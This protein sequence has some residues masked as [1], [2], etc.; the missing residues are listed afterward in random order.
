MNEVM[1]DV[2]SNA[3]FRIKYKIIKYIDYT[4]YSTF[5]KYYN[6]SSNSFIFRSKIIEQYTYN[7][8]KLFLLNFSNLKLLCIK[9]SLL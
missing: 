1:N 7:L 5:L 4:T 8:G 3:I 6:R 2:W 9:K